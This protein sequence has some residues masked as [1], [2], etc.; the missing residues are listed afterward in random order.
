MEKAKKEVDVKI[1]EAGENAMYETGVFGLNSELVRVLGRL[2]FRTSYG[3]NVL[4]HSIETSH[5]AGIMASEFGRKRGR[6]ASARVCC[7]I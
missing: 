4:R 2:R 7:T 1:K 6:C 3:Q 5:L